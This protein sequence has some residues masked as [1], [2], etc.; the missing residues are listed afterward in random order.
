MPALA[1]VLWLRNRDRWST[2]MRRWF[3]LSFLGLATYFVYPAAPPWWA[4]QH[5]LIA[6]V[7]RISTRGWKAIGLHGT[8]N[9]LQTG[10]LGSNPIAAMPS[11]HSA[12]ALLVAVTLMPMI[13]R[14]WR[15]LLLLYPFVMTMTLLYSGEH[16]LVDVLFGWAY[17]IVSIVIADAYGRWRS[18]RR[19]ASGV[20]DPVA[21]SELTVA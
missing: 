14:R 7:A 18:R 21:E 16:Y 1:L 15:W 5:G 10:Q 12:Y 6:P 11:L 4:S 8:G 2:L 19:A 20:P 9:L 3:V 17:A 13:A